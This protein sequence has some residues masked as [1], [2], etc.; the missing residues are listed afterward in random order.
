MFVTDH[1]FLKAESELK[2]LFCKCV[3]VPVSPDYTSLQKSLIKSWLYVKM[4][5]GL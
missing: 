3:P 2:S 5:G 1:T 4:D